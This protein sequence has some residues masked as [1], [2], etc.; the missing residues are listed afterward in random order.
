MARE[1]HGKIQAALQD[2]ASEDMMRKK[3]EP[4]VEEKKDPVVELAEK[5]L[6]EI[7]KMRESLDKIVKRFV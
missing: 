2:R 3:A 4:I 7:V 1:Q 5:M 6:E